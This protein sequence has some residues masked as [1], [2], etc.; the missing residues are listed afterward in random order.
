MVVAGIGS[1]DRGGVWAGHAH[2]E[3]LDQAQQGFEPGEDDDGGGH[4]PHSPGPP[5]R[6][7]TGGE[8]GGHRGDDE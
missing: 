3:K 1:A 6:H 4:Q 2:E 7:F 5:A 8:E